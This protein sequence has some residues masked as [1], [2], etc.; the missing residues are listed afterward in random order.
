MIVASFNRD[1]KNE[2]R[3]FSFKLLVIFPIDTFKFI[4]LNELCAFIRQLFCQY[5]K[6]RILFFVVDHIS[7]DCLI[8]FIYLNN[9]YFESVFR[10]ASNN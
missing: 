9:S 2:A 8:F 10:H 5:R 1:S 4:H 7:I 6:C 3:L